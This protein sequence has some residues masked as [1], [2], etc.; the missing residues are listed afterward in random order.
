MAAVV[1]A[2]AVVGV[3][4]SSV[5]DSDVGSTA[6]VP[7]AVEISTYYDG[8]P[9][10]VTRRPEVVCPDVTELAENLLSYATCEADMWQLAEWEAAVEGIVFEGPTYANG[11]PMITAV[12]PH[13]DCPD[14]VLYPELARV[15]ANICEADMRRLAEWEY[16]VFGTRPPEPRCISPEREAVVEYFDAWCEESTRRLAE[17]Q[18]EQEADHLRSLQARPLSGGAGVDVRPDVVRSTFALDGRMPFRDREAFAAL[19]EQMSD[20]EVEERGLNACAGLSEA[21][22][23]QDPFVGVGEL[24]AAFAEDFGRAETI[25]SPFDVSV[26]YLTAFSSAY[27][28]VEGERFAASLWSES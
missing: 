20:S 23:S 22:A 1:L 26:A 14:P 6:P 19:L 8:D 5:D 17:W 15:M 11:A 3:A 2:I 18:A 24:V 21:F 16:V 9:I 13:V 25:Q 7:E 28:P 27:C 4:C 12:A 10:D